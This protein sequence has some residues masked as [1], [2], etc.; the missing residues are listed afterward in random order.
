M[1]PLPFMDLLRARRELRIV[2]SIRYKLIKYKLILRKTDKSGVLHIG[3]AQDYQRKAIEYRQKTGAYEELPTNPL[4]QTFYKVIQVL[5]K[6]ETTKKILPKQ[7]N[8][9]L[10]IR[11]KTE[12]AYMYTVPKSHKVISSIQ[13]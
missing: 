2:R 1:A 8:K 12:L 7:K 11:K 5:N 3:H 4:N 9:M 13:F 10:P 6:L